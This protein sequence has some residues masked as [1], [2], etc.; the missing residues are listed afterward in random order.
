[1]VYISP[2]PFNAFVVSGTSSND[3]GVGGVFIHHHAPLFD[4]FST[5]ISANY[6][7]QVIGLSH[8]HHI[9]T[10]M[11]MDDIMVHKYFCCI[12]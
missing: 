2:Q 11:T 8:G 1:M 5:M 3:T 6:L 4:I 12:I 9:V 10:I 7:W